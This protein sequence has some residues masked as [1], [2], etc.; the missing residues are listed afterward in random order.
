MSAVAQLPRS[1]CAIP[2]TSRGFPFFLRLHRLLLYLLLPLSVTYVPITTQAGLGTLTVRD[3]VLAALWATTLSLFVDKCLTHH[4]LTKQYR[5]AF[6]IL[7]LANLPALLGVISSLSFDS[8]TPVLG[9]ACAHLKRFGGPSIITLGLLLAGDAAKYRMAK[10]A[11]LCL[12]LLVIVPHNFSGGAMQQFQTE[13][14][15]S[16]EERSSGLLTNPN[17]FGDVGV[18]VAFIV[19]GVMGRRSQYWT[20]ATI[21]LAAYVIIS[22]ASRSAMSAALVA[23]LFLLFKSRMSL[24]KKIGLA[25]LTAI[26]VFGGLHYSGVYRERVTSALSAEN[27]DSSFMA[28][29]DAQKISFIAWLHHPL[30]VGFANMPAATSEFSSDSSYV[31]AVNGSDSIY[32]DFLL[33][34]GLVGLSCILG[35][36]VVGG[37]L[38]SG[39]WRNNSHD[40]LVAGLI[41][42]ATF[43]LVTVSPASV[44]VSPFFFALLGSAPTKHAHVLLENTGFGV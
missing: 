28:R 20:W 13:D 42:S 9:D 10:I 32:F 40:Y 43:G 25:A 11:T 22:S 27:P 19:A 30:G 36:F 16:E 1:D 21:A 3:L 24:G 17:D 14:T 2:A 34:T 15:S 6:L 26:I 8:S 35:C 41:A 39:R 12:L 29:V 5:R 38:I 4:A 33:A 18:T 44:F 31:Y 7:V 23:V 37:K